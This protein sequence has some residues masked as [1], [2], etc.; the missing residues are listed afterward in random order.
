M[1]D[2]RNGFT[3]VE[4]LV[5][6]AIVAIVGLMLVVIFTNTLRGNNKAQILSVIKQNGQAVL[7]NMDKNIRN[8]DNVICN[9]DDGN[10]LVVTKDRTY[11]RYRFIPENNNNAAK[12]NCGNL[13]GNAN[14][15][16]QQDFPV[17][18]Q[19][20]P[21]NVIAVFLNSLCTDPMGTDSIPPQ[22]ITDTNPQTGVSVIPAKDGIGNNLPYFVRNSQSG[23]KDTVTI[24]FALKPGIQAPV[25][26]SGQ[27]DPIAFRTGIQ[28]R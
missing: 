17:Q 12:G 1:T 9:S 5:V 2:K 15:C 14:G 19:S 18:P 7:E 24:Q 10:T 26:V 20:A 23:F 21:K 8:A 11:T 13:S 22:T 4:I 16:I 6:I 28:L 3:L 27:I 25:S